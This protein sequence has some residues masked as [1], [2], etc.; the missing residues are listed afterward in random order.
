MIIN[1]VI[2]IKKL[3]NPLVN[4]ASLKVVATAMAMLLPMATPVSSCKSTWKTRYVISHELIKKATL[5]TSVF[6]LGQ[7]RKHRLPAPSPTIPPKTDA[8]T[9]LMVRMRRGNKKRVTSS[10]S[11]YARK[12]RYREPK[13]KG[14]PQLFPALLWWE[15]NHPALRVIS[16]TADDWTASSRTHQCDEKTQGYGR[17]INPAERWE[18]FLVRAS[19]ALK[20]R[21]NPSPSNRMIPY[22]R[23][24]SR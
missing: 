11:L 7:R 9:S 20:Y 12:Q 5:P 10:S 19:R 6:P 8:A 24:Y 14:L 22:R 1:E 15:G 16:R 4:A 23:A 13:N 3:S 21:Y 2:G 18:K 17:E